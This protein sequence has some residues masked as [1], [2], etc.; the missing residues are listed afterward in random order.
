MIPGIS[1]APCLAKKL[2]ERVLNSFWN[3]STGM[4]IFISVTAIRAD[5]RSTV[6]VTLA[7][8]SLVYNFPKRLA[9]VAMA[10]LYVP[11]VSKKMAQKNRITY[12]ETCLD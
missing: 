7:T 1:G 8:I 3:S 12:P 9:I 5:S 11:S 6:P 4:G 2:C 10:L